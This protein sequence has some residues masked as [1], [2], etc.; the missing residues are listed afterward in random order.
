MAAFGELVLPFEM[1]SG[2][3]S[4]IREMGGLLMTFDPARAELSPAPS[5]WGVRDSRIIRPAHMILI[6][7]VLSLNACNS[8]PPRPAPPAY[9]VT[10]KVTAPDGRSLAGAR[11]EFLPREDKFEFKAVGLADA[12][13]NFAL[14]IPFIARVIEG[15][16]EGPHRV[17]VTMALNA[18]REGG[19]HIPLPGELVVKPSENHFII[20]LPKGQ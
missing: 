20:E 10:G 15:A 8:K 17:S 5:G 11:I 3:A 16:T 9:P 1:S 6:A 7:C 18:N 14:K 2:S 12:N 4:A 19:K 13:G